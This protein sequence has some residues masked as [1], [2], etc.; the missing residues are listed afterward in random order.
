[1][2][3]P[4]TTGLRT[5]TR[6]V[7]LQRTGTSERAA[8]RSQT[9]D[10]AHLDAASVTELSEEAGEASGP[11]WRA[12][13][14]ASAHILAQDAEERMN[15]LLQKFV[16]APPGQPEAAFDLAT[17]V[18]DDPSDVFAALDQ[19]SQR[20]ELAPFADVLAQAQEFLTSVASPQWIVAGLDVALQAK[21]HAAATGVPA[22]DLRSECRRLIASIEEVHCV[23]EDWIRQYDERRR[24]IIVQFVS[25]EGEA[26]LWTRGWSAS[27]WDVD[28]LRLRLQLLRRLTGS[29]QAFVAPLRALAARRMIRFAVHA[30][31]ALALLYI[32]IVSG[33]VTADSIVRWLDSLGIDSPGRCAVMSSA[34]LGAVKMIGHD[35]FVDAASRGTLI[36]RFEAILGDLSDRERAARRGLIRTGC[37]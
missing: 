4:L 11:R 32:G 1:M 16:D 23:F 28:G 14:Y 5:S 26:M 2:S 29:E 27:A 21:E 13:R 18:F 6:T 20:E 22:V 31:A 33:E 25:D 24:R 30:D 17:S 3:T 19:L 10:A 34:V 37:A 7:T 12:R 8:Q 36:A 9:T 15:T 35:V